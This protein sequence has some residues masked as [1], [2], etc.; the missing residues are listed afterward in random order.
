MDQQQ[1]SQ[2]FGRLNEVI[3]RAG[4]EL[5]QEF[6]PRAESCYK[7]PTMDEFDVC[8]K[9]LTKVHESSTREFSMR[10]QF[11][12]NKFTMCLKNGGN[13]DDCLGDAKKSLRVVVRDLKTMF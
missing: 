1:L 9:G 2:A 10:G 4:Q 11:V 3:D 8:V 7:K 6:H 5:S 13:M 12:A